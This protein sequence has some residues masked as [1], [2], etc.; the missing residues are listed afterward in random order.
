MY[1]AEELRKIQK[2]KLE[3]L[4]DIVKFCDKNKL[5]YWLDSGT[6]LG[7]V[8]HGGFIPWDDDI[9]IIMLEEDGKKLKNNY[10]SENFEITSTKEGYSNFLK[11][12][13]RKRKLN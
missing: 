4:V 9:D 7:A 6:L 5:T 2:K 8:R 3:I 10:Q 13:Q 1:N 11:Q 12:F